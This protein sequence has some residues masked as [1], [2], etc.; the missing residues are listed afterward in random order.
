MCITWSGVRCEGGPFSWSLKEKDFDCRILFPAKLSFNSEG[1]W[2]LFSVIERLI[3][4]TTHIF[5]KAHCWM[6]YSNRIFFSFSFSWQNPYSFCLYRNLQ[7]QF[8]CLPK[9]L[10]T[11]FHFLLH[12]VCVCLCY[13]AF[14]VTMLLILVFI[15][16]NNVKFICN[17]SVH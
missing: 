11:L 8:E 10:C 2:E 16:N 6:I 17:T 3:K 1:N 15:I 7:T 13:C 9:L 5:F 14:S 12:R 4:Y